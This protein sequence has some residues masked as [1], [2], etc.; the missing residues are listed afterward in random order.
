[1]TDRC[2]G[3]GGEVRDH[4]PVVRHNAPFNRPSERLCQN[5]WHEP[6]EE[7]NVAKK[8]KKQMTPSEFIDKVEC[9]GGILEALDYGLR[10]KD[11][12]DS[13]PSFKAAWQRLETKF[14]LMHGDLSEV[15]SMIDCMDGDEEDYD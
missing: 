1:M 15:E 4:R 5:A 7:G 14:D 12:D 11:M 8:Q 3:C 10:A 6:T 2:P 13:D 9:E